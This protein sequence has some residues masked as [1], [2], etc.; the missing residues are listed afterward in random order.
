MHAVRIPVSGLGGA[1]FTAS[2]FWL[3]WSFVETTFEAGERVEP[4][5]VEFSRMVRDTE[6]ATTR[7]ERIERELPPPTPE[8]PRIG[9]TGGG[10]DNDVAILTPVTDTGSARTRMTMTAGSDRDVIPLV[11]INPDY[12]PAAL[13]RELEGWVQ[14]QFT[15]TPAG[16]VE[17]AIVVDAEPQDVFDDAALKAIVRWRYNPK[18]ENG[19]AVERV[20]VQTR[21]VFRLEQ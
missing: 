18:V 14:V 7:Q 16:S 20:G 17:D 9:F 5:R 21:I 11:R 15:I 1:L 12:P 19:V 10:V 2:M 3:L 8:A 6:A 13:R 4:T